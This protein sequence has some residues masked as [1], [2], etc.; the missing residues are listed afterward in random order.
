MLMSSTFIRRNDKCTVCTSR[1]QT[2][3]WWSR[4]EKTATIIFAEEAAAE[5]GTASL[6]SIFQRGSRLQT[7]GDQITERVRMSL[8]E[9]EN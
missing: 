6:P 1:K 8:Q 7:Q 9:A 3:D 2:E 4:G 5:E